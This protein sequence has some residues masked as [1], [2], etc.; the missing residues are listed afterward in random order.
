MFIIIMIILLAL[1][2]LFFIL[3]VYVFAFMRFNQGISIFFVK[4]YPI[5]TTNNI[6][7]KQT[8][9]KTN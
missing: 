9:N 3:F 6:N 1:T 8:N 2:A 7:K 5:N 4:K